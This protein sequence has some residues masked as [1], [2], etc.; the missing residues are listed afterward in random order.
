MNIEETPETTEQPVAE[1]V[2]EVKAKKPRAPRK[3]KPAPGRA[4]S[5]TKA[6]PKA[7]TKPVAIVT[8][9]PKAAPVTARIEKAK[10]V[11]VALPP[12]P[13]MPS[14]RNR[15]PKATQPCAC[16]C[17]TMTQRTW[18]PGHDARANGW[19]IRIERDICKMADVPENERPGVKIQLAKRKAEGAAGGIKIVKSDKKVAGE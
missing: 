2:T 10:A 4:M 3:D 7:K 5:A 19:A 9:K 15:K 11:K 18:A 14:V 8:D 17:G 16:G 6:A 12:L 13:K 1:V